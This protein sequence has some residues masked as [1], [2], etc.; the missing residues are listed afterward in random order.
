MSGSV[1]ALEYAMI[2]VRKFQPFL[3][4]YARAVAMPETWLDAFMADREHIALEAT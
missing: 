3:K 1:F 4:V 2:T